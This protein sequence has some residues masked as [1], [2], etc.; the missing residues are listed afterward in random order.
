[1]TLAVA[2]LMKDPQFSK[3]RLQGALAPELREGLSLLMFRNTLEHV[4]NW[5]VTSKEDRVLGVVTPSDKIARM[6]VDHGAEVVSERTPAGIDA[7]S[8]RAVSWAEA[9]GAEALL[10]MHADLPLVS[11][12]E[13]DA[14]RDAAQQVDVVIASSNDG[15]TNA[16]M[17]SLPSRIA[18][19]F[20]ADSAARH[21]RHARAA[22]ASHL[23]LQLPGLAQDLDTPDALAEWLPRRNATGFS[24]QVVT[25]L[26]EFKAGDDIALAIRQSLAADDVTLQAGD[27]VVVAQKVVSKCEGR[28]RRL[29]DYKPSAEA[30]RI[31]DVTGKDP[32]KVEAI[33]RESTDVLRAVP[34]PPNGILITRHRNGWICANAGIDESNLGPNADDHVLLL[35]EDGDESARRIRAWLEQDAAGPIGVI[36]SDTFG[37]PWRHGLVNIAIGV[38]G[39]SAVVDMAGSVDAGGRPLVATVPA[40]ADEL[41]ASAG[42]LM[43]KDGGTPVVVIRGLNWR[44]DPTA[45]ARDVLREKSKELFL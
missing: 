33:L 25:G 30:M 36:V 11:E 13:L 8:E 5:C 41:A 27:I 35:P 45:S 32:R 39:I 3:T 24:A 29:A 7:A 1:M 16:L 12:A 9:Q 17:L 37:R 31:A 15:G 14:L 2:I 42:L 6:A 26:P 44:D 28:L 10:L 21:V 19:G 20:G 22:G 40:L 23:T 18:F 34:A 4:Q 43:H 38:A